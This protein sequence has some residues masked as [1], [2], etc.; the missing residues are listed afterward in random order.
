MSGDQ[1]KA[2][3]PFAAEARENFRLT[4][5]VRSGQPLKEMDEA[6]RVAATKWVDA[7]LSDKG[8]LKAMRIIT[9]EGVLADLEKNPGFRDAGKYYLSLFGKPGDAAGWDW[10]VCR[11]EGL[12]GNACGKTRSWE[13]GYRQF[14]ASKPGAV[15][16]KTGNLQPIQTFFRLHEI[17][18]DK[19]VFSVNLRPL[20]PNSR[21]G[22]RARSMQ[23]DRTRCFC[24]VEGRH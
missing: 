6:Q 10:G 19:D 9:L 8:H 17:F 16:A 20:L 7:A 11:H 21:Q 24:R 4:P 5:Q 12:G 23:S 1:I 22:Y 15:A 13:L 18:F 14:E 3:F 2:R